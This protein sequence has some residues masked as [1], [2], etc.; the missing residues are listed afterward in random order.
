MLLHLSQ[1]VT[2]N[3]LR[4]DIFMLCQRRKNYNIND[5]S[6]NG[7][8]TADD[9]KK[10]LIMAIIKLTSWKE[11]S[12]IF[13]FSMTLIAEWSKY[14][15]GYQRITRSRISNKLISRNILN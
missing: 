10:M 12:Y 9:Y 14:L 4:R 7:T 3:I 15:Q 5:Y 11:Y 8:F 1:V 13:I 6:M 2:V